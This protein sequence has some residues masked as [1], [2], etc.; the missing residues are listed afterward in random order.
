MTERDFQ[1]LLAAIKRFDAEHNSPD[2]ARKVL[3]EEGV[4]T[5]KG[6]IAEPYAKPGQ[7]DA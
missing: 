4:L 6:E 7:A 1:E 2:A 3:Q 5:E